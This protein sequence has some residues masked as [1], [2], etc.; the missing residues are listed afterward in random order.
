MNQQSAGVKPSL[1]GAAVL[2]ACAC[3]ASSR[4]A[5]LSASYGGAASSHMIHP[6]FLAVGGALILLGLWRRQ[7]RLPFFALIGL[8]L[9]MAGEFIV[10][11]M[12][13]TGSTQFH[14]T[15]LLGLFSSIVA[16]AFL[17]FAFYMLIRLST[18][19]LR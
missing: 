16:A 1:A 8:A 10:R 14:S 4:L 19:G 9:L 13:I 11:P 7:Q 3:G 17:V 5:G 12:S 2:A 6:F 18:L 15:Q